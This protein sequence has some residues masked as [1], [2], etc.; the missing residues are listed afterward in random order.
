MNVNTPLSVPLCVCV[1]VCVCVFVCS[2][3]HPHILHRYHCIFAHYIQVRILCVCTAI[4]I[5]IVIA[6]VLMNA[7][8]KGNLLQVSCNLCYHVRECWSYTSLYM[9]CFGYQRLH[10]LFMEVYGMLF[11]LAILYYSFDYSEC[12]SSRLPYRYS[13]LDYGKCAYQII[14]YCCRHV[15]VTTV[16]LLTV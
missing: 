11:Q 13:W 6:P 14:P 5:L 2:T 1:C 8:E 9:P 3:E 15:V 4:M 10:V 16:Y 7:L 12:H